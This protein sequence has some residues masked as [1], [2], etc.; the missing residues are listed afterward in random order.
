MRKFLMT[1]LG[2]LCVLALASCVTIETG[3]KDDGTRYTKTR[4]TGE[5]T[6]T[7]DVEA[8]GKTSV[9]GEAF[10]ISDAGAGTIGGIVSGVASVF[11][12]GG[13]GGDTIVNV[14]GGEISTTPDSD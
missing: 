1:V 6:V 14:S 4:M 10:G 2:V 7:I 12:G 3:T 13:D 9:T 11:G 5:G 8:D